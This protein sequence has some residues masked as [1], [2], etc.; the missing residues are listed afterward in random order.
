MQEFTAVVTIN[1]GGLSVTATFSPQN[2]YVYNTDD[3]LLATVEPGTSKIIPDSLIKDTA[4]ALKY[5]VPAT[6]QQV[7]QDVPVINSAAEEI[8]RGR[9]EQTVVIADKALTNSDLSL[10]TPLVAGRNKVLADIPVLEGDGVTRN[11]PAAVAVNTSQRTFS[12]AVT[13]KALSIMDAQFQIDS[14]GVVKSVSLTNVASYT[15]THARAGVFTTVYSGGAFVAFSVQK[16]DILHISAV[17]TDTAQDRVITLL[18]YHDV[19]STPLTLPT[20]NGDGRYLY[21]LCRVSQNIHV[22][23]VTTHLVIAIITLPASANWGA[24]CFR[25]KDQSGWFFSSGSYA[26][27]DCNPASGT[28][29]TVL[30]T[31]GLSLAATSAGC[32]YDYVNDFIYLGVQNGTYKFNPNTFANTRLDTLVG[33]GAPRHDQMRYI[34]ALKQVYLGDIQ[35]SQLMWS[36]VT[37]TP[38]YSFVAQDLGQ[39]IYNHKNGR[40]YHVG[41]GIVR[42]RNANPIKLAAAVA[43]AANRGDAVFVPS[44]DKLFVCNAFGNTLGVVNT[45]T[46]TNITTITK[47]SPAANELGNRSIVYSPVSDRVY[48]QASQASGAVTG[49]DRVH[50]INPNTNAYQSF[51][52][53]GNCDTNNSNPGWVHQ[54]F[55]NKVRI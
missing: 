41:N 46:N 31:G 37:D 35:S 49:V 44:L 15:I 51:I 21:V 33:I 4:G 13:I 16:D 18:G 17:A 2:G 34:H 30:A 47:T 10:N 39:M 55:L 11:Y 7:I 23:D 12:H 27:V 9:A 53:V 42:V 8:G 50:I 24:C 45:S 3:E 40:L 28:W 14:Q 6:Q 29:N 25:D 43:C 38:T 48:V 52:V 19:M 5:S 26:K 54:M 20:S 36:T 22:I 1:T 32:C